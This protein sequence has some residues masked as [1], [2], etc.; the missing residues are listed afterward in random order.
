M[1]HGRLCFLSVLK[2]LIKLDDER[3]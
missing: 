3:S 1:S 2:I